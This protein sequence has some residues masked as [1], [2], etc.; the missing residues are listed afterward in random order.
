MTE[1]ECVFVEEQEP[2]GRPILP[3]CIVCSTTAMDALSALVAERDQAIAH[4]RQPYPTAWAYEQLA[5][6]HKE[7]EADRDR[8]REALSRIEQDP[9]AEGNTWVAGMARSALAAREA[10]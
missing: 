8:L 1:H 9:R 3:P 2:T 6:A 5:K 10:S 7:T 4:D